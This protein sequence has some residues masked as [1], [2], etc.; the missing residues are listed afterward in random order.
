M[1]TNTELAHEHPL[2]RV[3]LET[4]AAG[5]QG[6]DQIAGIVATLD[7]QGREIKAIAER[8]QASDV[9]T[10][11]EAIQK[12]TQAKLQ[13]LRDVNDRRE[14]EEKRRGAED[15]LDRDQMRRINASIDGDERAEIKRLR[16]E[17]RQL[18]IK[19]ARPALPSGSGPLASRKA[20]EAMAHEAALHYLRTGERQYKGRSI[21]DYEVAAYG[22]KA[23]TAHSGSGQ[24]GGYLVVPERDGSIERLLAQVVPMRR[25]AS[26]KTIT[27]KS[28]EK[29]VRTS[30]GGAQWGT[31]LTSSGQS[32]PPTFALLDFP[33][34]NLYA[35]P[36]VSAD[37][38]EDSMYDIV[39]E[40]NA[41]AL[42]DFEV[43]ESLAW[44]SGNGV[45]KPFGILGYQSSD[46]VAD[47]SWTWGKVG[48]KVT[49]ASG[50]FPTS[51]GSTGSGDPIL[52]LP[53]ALKQQ[54]RNAAKWLANRNTIG[55]CRILKDGN[56]A[57][58]WLQGDFARGIPNTLAGYEVVEAEQ[59]PDI[60]ANSFSLA[61]ADWE[62]AFVIV[63]RVGMTV[64]RDELTAYPH[65]AFKTR[66]RAGGGIM[67]FEAIKL[68]KFST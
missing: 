46:Y 2:R 65:I 50:A 28:Y 62:R 40:I 64:L 53:M 55:S 27:T 63:D 47:G 19:A 16:E 39:G 11:V 68:L 52:T 56:G 8:Q 30:T 43:A 15:P 35:E 41:G 67:N 12:S 9:K 24:S 29:P 7:Q 36:R 66:K 10:R 22:E 3:Q 17:N 54:Y 60:A 23:T 38:V 44:I 31:E 13:E 58:V 14:R 33:A 26:V 45:G 37:L 6:N 51:S 4:K 57:Y 5:G 34:H 42:E 1:T 48:Y 61:F 25:L 21:R 32:N 59:M 20:A 49:G 18:R